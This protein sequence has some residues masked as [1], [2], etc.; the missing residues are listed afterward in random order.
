MNSNPTTNP[1]SIAPFT[2]DTWQ[3]WSALWK[4]RGYQ[5]N[6]EGIV[7]EEDDIPPRGMDVG[8]DG[9]EWD[10]HHIDE[11]Y[12]SGTGGFWLAYWEGD[13]AGHV[14]AQDLG[15]TIELRHMYVRAEYRRRGIGTRLVQALIDHCKS[16]AVKAVE[17]WTAPDGLG[18]IL[19]KKLGFR[20]ADKPWMELNELNYRMNSAP[21]KG[22]IRMRVNLS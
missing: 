1:I 3:H 16:K 2:W 5:L 12:L 18:R 22:E 8:R 6:E 10:Y 20:V 17:L 15:G 4:L 11:I 21:G 7:G 13:P 9:Y 14:G 19:Y